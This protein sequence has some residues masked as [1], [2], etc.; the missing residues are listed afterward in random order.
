[1]FSLA[2]ISQYEGSL[3]LLN[4]I[5]ADFGNIHGHHG[6]DGQCFHK[7]LR[8]NFINEINKVID[9]HPKIS[10]K[11]RGFFQTG[12]RKDKSSDGGKSISREHDTRLIPIYLLPRS[13]T[14]FG[15][16]YHG[17]LNLRFSDNTKKNKIVDEHKVGDS[18][19]LIT[20]HQERPRF[21]INLIMNQM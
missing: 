21:G 12:F 1:M 3:S 6:I 16:N 5:Y 9:R 14:K 20:N 8:L 17:H 4:F 7:E 18:R 2:S 19:I 13:I 11:R 15:K 10:T